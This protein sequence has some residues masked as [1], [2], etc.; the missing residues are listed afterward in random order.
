MRNQIYQELRGSVTKLTSITPTQVSAISEG[1]VSYEQLTSLLDEYGLSIKSVLHDEGRAFQN[2]YYADMERGLYGEL[3]LQAKPFESGTR[4]LLK[5][6]AS[7][8][9][10]DNPNL[11]SLDWE[12][13]YFLDIPLSRCLK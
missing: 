3:Y 13:Y 6:L 1:N 8:L 11:T 2:T 7:R 4:P 9:E 5:H 12:S 10:C